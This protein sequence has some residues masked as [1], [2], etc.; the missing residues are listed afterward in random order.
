MINIPSMDNYNVGFV[1]SPSME[2]QKQILSY[3]VHNGESVADVLQYFHMTL[4]ELMYYNDTNNI[5]LCPG[6]SINVCNYRIND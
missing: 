6:K 5:N 1:E 3:V 2:Q 4:E